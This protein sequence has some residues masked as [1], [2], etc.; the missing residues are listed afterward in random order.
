LFPSRTSI[1]FILAHHRFLIST[2]S[3]VLCLFWTRLLLVTQFSQPMFTTHTSTDCLLH[4]IFTD[5]HSLCIF[6]VTFGLVLYFICCTPIFIVHLT[7]F[8]HLTH[9]HA[10][11]YYYYFFFFFSL[12]SFLL[13][14]FL[15]SFFC[16]LSIIFFLLKKRENKNVLNYKN[17]KKIEKKNL[18][19][20]N[21]LFCFI[22]SVRSSHHVTLIF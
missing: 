15:L 1:L 17:Y 18:K 13:L 11:Y 5:S 10:P 4:P 19:N 12:L 8:M 7:C 21:I 3:Y 6:I 14:N 20:E 9:Y 2:H 16:Y 22:V